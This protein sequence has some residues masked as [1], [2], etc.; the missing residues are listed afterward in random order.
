MDHMKTIHK[1][2]KMIEDV[3]TNIRSLLTTHE[4]NINVHDINR[5]TTL[6]IA[7][8]DSSN[9]SKAQADYTC[10]GVDDQIQIQAAIDSLNAI[11]GDIY[12]SPGVFNISSV[13]NITVP[14]TW[15]GS[16]VGEHWA[17]SAPYGYYGS[18]LSA[19]AGFTGKMINISGSHY[20][21]G[22]YNLGISGDNM[23]PAVL[24]PNTAVDVDNAGDFV[25]HHCFLFNLPFQSAIRLNNHGSWIDLCDFEYNRLVT[26]G[27]ID[28]TNY[29]NWITNCYFSTNRSAIEISSKWQHIHNCVFTNSKRYHIGCASPSEQ[30]ISSCTFETW[31][32]D[33][34]GWAAIRFYNSP[35]YNHIINSS[36]NATGCNGSE[37]IQDNGTALDYCNINNNIFYGFGATSPIDLSSAGTHN[38]V[39]NNIGY[40]TE[41][42]GTATLVNGTTSIAVSHGLAVTPSAGDI[43][44]TP[45]EAWG[46]M[47][48]FY[49]DTYTATQ[50]TIHADINPAQDVD[51]VWKA[52]VI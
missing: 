37:G 12:L 18:I 42:S 34:S 2:F 50:F 6:T 52:V 38:I 46:N 16:G 28:A 17:G 33:N 1:L 51:F 22:F 29:R 20:G 41:N 49:I 4:S 19:V 7:S 9:L 23:N 25:V 31:N 44:V 13:I 21:G 39:R 47:T 24:I 30:K 45:I 40:I 48:Q 14:I 35:L 36:F 10:D 3:D 8:N 32:S 27:A 5:S 43:I 15:H 26:A 11:G